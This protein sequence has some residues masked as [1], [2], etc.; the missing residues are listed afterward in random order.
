M[1][2]PSRNRGWWRELFVDHPGIATKS[3]DAYAGDKHR[4]W[5]KKCFSSR[6]SAEIA[7]DEREIAAG[8]R[9][10]VRDQQTIES[11]C[12]YTITSRIHTVFLDAPYSMG[13]GTEG[14]WSW[15]ECFRYANTCESLEGVQFTAGRYQTGS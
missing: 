12:T 15:M 5:C 13:N 2:P 14:S 1:A 3:S 4:V 7:Q 10:S 8:I 11:T 9:T 6:I